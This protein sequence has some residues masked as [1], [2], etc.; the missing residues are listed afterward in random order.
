LESEYPELRDLRYLR[1]E[2]RGAF[3]MPSA[4]GRELRHTLS[5]PTPAAKLRLRSDHADVDSV[6]KM[7]EERLFGWIAALADGSIPAG[8]ANAARVVV[9][10]LRRLQDAEDM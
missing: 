4:Y 6:R 8:S 10:T 3:D 1:E 2:V 9:A 7:A 5:Q